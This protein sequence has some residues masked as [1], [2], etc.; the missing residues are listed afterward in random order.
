IRKITD[1]IIKKQHLRVAEIPGNQRTHE[2]ITT[3]EPDDIPNVS[4]LYN[5]AQE[6]TIGFRK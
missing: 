5:L 1:L 4:D 6:N 2:L 3:I